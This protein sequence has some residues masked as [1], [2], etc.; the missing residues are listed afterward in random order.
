MAQEFRQ[1][2]E[3]FNL[4]IKAELGFLAD[5]LKK[6]NKAVYEQMV[7]TEQILKG[8]GY[9]KTVPKRDVSQK[10]HIIKVHFNMTK[11]L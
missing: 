4:D 2:V 11:H 3:E 7:K 6:M 9:P 8:K 10:I 5:E 1:E